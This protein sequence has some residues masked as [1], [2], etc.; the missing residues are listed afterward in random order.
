MHFCPLHRSPL[1]R[2]KIIGMC[3]KENYSDSPSNEYLRHYSA[4]PSIYDV[5]RD[6]KYAFAFLVILHLAAQSVSMVF[7]LGILSLQLNGNTWAI[8]CNNDNVPHR[9]LIKQKRQ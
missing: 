6:G 5:S 4:S 1:V 9:Y 3:L 8:Q 2:N 7:G